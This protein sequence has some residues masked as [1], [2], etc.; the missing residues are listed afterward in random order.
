[1][2]YHWLENGREESHQC[3]ADHT[4]GHVAGLDGTVEQH[5]V[6]SQQGTAARYLEKLLP[7]NTRQTGEHDEY[8]RRK[9]HAIPY[10]VNLVEG[11]EFSKQAG[12][13]CKN[14]A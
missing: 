14:N 10:D 7:A 1:M 12:E 11:D 4:Y 9:Q 8:G 2:E 6:K 13:A 3:K 5:P